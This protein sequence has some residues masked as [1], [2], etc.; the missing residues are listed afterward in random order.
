MYRF[1]KQESRSNVKG[2]PKEKR[3]EIDDSSTLRDIV[4]EVINRVSEYV[5]IRILPGYNWSV[6]INIIA[7][8]LILV[9]ELW[10][11][12]LPGTLPAFAFLGEDA[13]PEHWKRNLSSRAKGP[14]FEVSG[15]DCL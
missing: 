10:S 7:R 5:Y 9:M 15:K 3:L 11:Q 13:V 12:G 6:E 1:S 8:H 2:Q 14:I 4:Q